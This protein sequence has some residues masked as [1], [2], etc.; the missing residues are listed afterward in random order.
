MDALLHRFAFLTAD[1]ADGADEKNAA[2]FPMSTES[3]PSSC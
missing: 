2:A 3:S 1:F